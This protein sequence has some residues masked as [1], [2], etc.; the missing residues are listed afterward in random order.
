MFPFIQL[1]SLLPY[2]KKENRVD[3]ASTLEE[4]T[5]RAPSWL[6]TGQRHVISSGPGLQVVKNMD[7]I[8]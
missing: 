3:L 8:A 7:S 4:L 2:G 5:V 6:A 1:C